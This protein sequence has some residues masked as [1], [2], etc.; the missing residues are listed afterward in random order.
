VAPQHQAQLFD[1]LY[2]SPADPQG[3]EGGKG[4]G[5]AIVKRIVELHHGS[6]AL[7]SAPG[8]GTTVTITLP[9]SGA[10]RPWASGA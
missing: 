2:R 1:R 3:S 6:V 8:Q 4:L 5:L 9:V 10:G 7:E